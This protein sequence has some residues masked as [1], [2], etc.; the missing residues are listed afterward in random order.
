[1]IPE[2]LRARISF[3]DVW[4]KWQSRAVRSLRKRGF[5]G[6]ITFA[7]RLAKGFLLQR[8]VQYGRSN[9]WR[10]YLDRRFD[11][12]FAVDT[13]GILCLPE[14]QSNHRFQHSNHYEP[15]NSS[16][17]ARALRQL[18]VD[19]R[20]FVFIDL[21]CGKGKALLLASDWPFRQV[22]GVE[23]SPILLE[24]AERNIATYRGKKEGCREFRLVCADACSY[25]LPPDNAVLFFFNPFKE[26][27][28]REVLENVGRS[29][30]QCPRE[31]FIIYEYPVL[32]R[33]TDALPFLSLVRESPWYR[34]YKV[35]R[36][37]EE[38]SVFLNRPDAE[39]QSTEVAG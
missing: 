32:C 19:Y 24:I 21:G 33:M 17:F 23:L 35:V 4:K 28:L 36:C 29:V 13:A 1:M 6:T 22:I 30:A 34:I 9:P 15:T 39:A 3:L 12:R 16:V 2:A 25:E 20:K 5:G 18:A 7:T 11:R 38:H 8:W 31:V 14:L 27:T 10:R 37:A 26:P